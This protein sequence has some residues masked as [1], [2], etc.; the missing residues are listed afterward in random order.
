M[1]II[2]STCD[3]YAH[4]M[5]GFAWCWNKYW[6]VPVDVLGFK[7]FDGLPDNFTFHS[8]DTE[9]KRPW[10][11]YIAEWLGA[12]NFH[13]AILLFDDYWLTKP[14]DEARVRKMED[15]VV[16]GADKADLSGNTKYFAHVQL[17]PDILMARPTAQYRASTQPAIWRRQY[18][19]RCL[20]P[21]LSPWQFELQA[22]VVND[23]ARIVGPVNPIIEMG[24]Q[25]ANVY[26]KGEWHCFMVEKIN[27]A[28]RAE[29]I[30]AGHLP[31]K[32]R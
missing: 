29:L 9:E 7:P 17:T 12:Q 16:L 27:P 21:G 20:R 1:R 28:D 15:E 4:L 31:E 14:V 19:M 23:G 30:A 32:Y 5:G 25:Y 10:S 2:V 24:N 18:L 22:G 11:D 3:K 26:L 6:G 8:L 13:H